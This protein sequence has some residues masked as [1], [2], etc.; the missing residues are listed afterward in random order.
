MVTT[1]YSTTTPIIA[2]AKQNFNYPCKREAYVNVCYA[3]YTLN[4]AAKTAPNGLRFMLY[5]LKNRWIE[6]LYR[7][8]YCVHAELGERLV[9]Y[10]V[11]KVDG[12]LFKWHLPSQR[13][14]WPIQENRTAVFYE[15]R[16]E[17]PQREESLEKAVALLEW[18][19]A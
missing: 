14:T 6:R 7:E 1:V 5:R 2:R 13:I 12:I 9:W 17:M 16:N 3:C 18:C 19:L 4:Q 8:G 11:F 15:W 10:L